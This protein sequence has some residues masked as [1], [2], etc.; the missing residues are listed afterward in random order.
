MKSHVHSRQHELLQVLAVIAS[1]FRDSVL[2]LAELVHMLETHHTLGNPIQTRW[3]EMITDFYW[4]LG[5]KGAAMLIMGTEDPVMNLWAFLAVP[6]CLRCHCQAGCQ[7][8]RP[9]HLLCVSVNVMQHA[10]GASA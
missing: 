4:A 8:L 1:A 7:K 9:M 10:Q 3:G 2:P 5:H 6:C